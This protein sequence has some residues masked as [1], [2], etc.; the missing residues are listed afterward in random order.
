MDIDIGT[1]QR[2]LDWLVTDCK[3]RFDEGTNP[4]NYSPELTEAIEVRDELQEG[5]YVLRADRL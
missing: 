1:I 4:G 2:V 3:H 5:K